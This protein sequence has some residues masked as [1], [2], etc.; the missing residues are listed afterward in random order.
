M[1]IFLKYYRKKAYRRCR[2]TSYI[3]MDAATA[4]FKDS[5]FPFMGMRTKV[6]AQPLSSS[7]KPLPSLPMKKAQPVR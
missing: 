3:N 7:L 1:H 5:N 6:S 4:A 2:Q